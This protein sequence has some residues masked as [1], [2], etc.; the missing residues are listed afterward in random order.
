MFLNVAR[1]N[2]PNKMVTIRPHDSPWFTTHLRLLKRKCHRA[3]KK[4]K[5]TSAPTDWNRYRTA[6]NLYHNELDAAE[7]KYDCTLSASLA[8]SK[9]SK[10]WWG[11]VK[12]LL[13]KGGDI[14]SY[15]SLKV[16][17]TLVTDNRDKANTFN[18][19]YLSHS[20]IDTS[21]A[22]LPDDQD[23]PHNLGEVSAAEG[24]V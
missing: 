2:I 20:N 12:Q 10:S 22:T 4:F 19:F 21:N 15:P 24:E 8:T 23:F 14:S 17:D 13:G 3:F 1:T 7:A 5:K 16:R 6:C 11:T 9:N 18:S